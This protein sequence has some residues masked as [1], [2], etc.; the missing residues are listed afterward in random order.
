VTC[1]GSFERFTIE[2]DKEED[3]KKTLT[4]TG[5]S[6]DRLGSTGSA[7]SLTT[8]NSENKASSVSTSLDINVKID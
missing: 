6:R 3:M 1:P 2:N 7:G 5:S 8:S 4:S